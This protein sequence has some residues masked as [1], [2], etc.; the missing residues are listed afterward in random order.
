MNTEEAKT[1]TLNATFAK[2]IAEVESSWEVISL[3]DEYYNER[4]KDLIHHYDT[5]IGLWATDKPEEFEDKKDLLFELKSN[6]H[7]KN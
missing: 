6:N 1:V 5:T 3:L 7:E 4:A 2:K